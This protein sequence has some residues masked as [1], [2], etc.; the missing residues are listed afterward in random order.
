MAR[1]FQIIAEPNNPLRQVVHT[2]NEALAVLG[3]QS[4]RFEPLE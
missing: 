2:I 4:P 1:M 3:V